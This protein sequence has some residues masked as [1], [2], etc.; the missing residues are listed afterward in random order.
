MGYF[1]QAD[2]VDLFGQEGRRIFYEFCQKIERELL[3]TIRPKFDQVSEKKNAYWCANFKK[4]P[5]S[6]FIFMKFE[7][8]WPFVKLKRSQVLVLRYQGLLHFNYDEIVFL[9]KLGPQ[10]S[11]LPTR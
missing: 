9:F 2:E 10:N 7:K 4:Y 11:L 6:I 8:V 1:S 3:I 5:E